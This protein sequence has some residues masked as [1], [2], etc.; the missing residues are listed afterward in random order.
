MSDEPV[1]IGAPDSGKNASDVTGLRRKM[2]TGSFWMIGVNLFRRGVGVISTIV[3]ARL[4]PP[5]DF[6]LVAMASVLVVMMQAVTEFG[7]DVALIQKQNCTRTHYDTAWTF[8]ILFATVSALVLV[9]LAWP[10]AEFY[11][12]ARVMPIV[13]ALSIGVLLRGFENIGIVDFRKDFEFN[14]EFRFFST[15]KLSAATVTIILAIIFRSYWALV[16]G[17]I[18][19]RIVGLILSYTM[20]PY[21]PRFS[22]AARAELFGF[23]AWLF[24]NNILMFVRTRGADF[25]VGR[26]LGAR[27]LGLFT[28]GTE[29]A[30]L[31]T[32]ELIAPINRAIFPGY[33]KISD[34]PHRMRQAFLNVFSVISI[35][36]IPSAIGIAVISTT[37]IPVLLG[38]KWLDAI[39]LVHAMAIVGLLTSLHSNTG[40]AYFALGKPRIHVVL[41]SISAAILLPCAFIFADKFGIVGVAY[42][43]L[44]ANGS[45]F[46]IN[47]V[48]AVR[49]L[50]IPPAR[51]VASVL[52]PTIAAAAMYL[53]V[54]ESQSVLKLHVPDVV[55]LL[56]SILCGAAVF[57]SVVT[58]LW[59]TMGRPRG[60]ETF[61]LEHAR[62]VPVL[63]RLARILAP[64]A[65]LA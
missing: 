18:T 60:A 28:I 41:Q 26:V 6:G 2:I 13:L 54:A 52:R 46:L 59:I 42:A 8:K 27:S 21:R 49:L 9:T 36:A 48:V 25:I 1:S 50:Q 44:L 3:L 10:A 58:V 51:L 57:V 63:R 19:S 65:G 15:I 33:S 47:C 45:T 38:P 14:R 20:S 62:R 5:A 34:D 22:I 7:F 37:A 40:A 16:I 24:L 32:T 61:I 30:S 23:S 31:P 35:I 53:A 55:N 64:D 39:P 43:Y 56:L 12:E 17:M 4:L 29:I 11:S